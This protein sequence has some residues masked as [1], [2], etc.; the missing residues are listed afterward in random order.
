MLETNKIKA[1]K[2]RKGDQIREFSTITKASR[3]MKCSPAKVEELFKSK[4][5]YHGWRVNI[6]FYHGC[7]ICGADI[8]RSDDYCD[9]CYRVSLNAPE[10][11]FNGFHSLGVKEDMP[12][13]RGY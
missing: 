12:K 10:V 4:S 1:V 5:E 2:V 3:F 7:C 6:V 13:V 8:K 9:P 11:G